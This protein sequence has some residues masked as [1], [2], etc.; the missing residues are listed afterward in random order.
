MSE[1]EY[2]LSPR[3]VKPDCYRNWEAIGLGVVPV[4][5]NN[6]TL[7]SFTQGAILEANMTEFNTSRYPECGVSDCSH[8]PLVRDQI[9]LPYWLDHFQCLVQSRYGMQVNYRE[10]AQ[11]AKLTKQ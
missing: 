9:L 11:I 10:T 5:N 7:H 8:A 3:G 2:V 1:H 6:K 4:T